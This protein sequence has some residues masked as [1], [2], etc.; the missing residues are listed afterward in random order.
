MSNT[1]LLDS[2][3]GKIRIKPGV[4][5]DDAQYVYKNGQCIALALALNKLTGWPIIAHL[6]R[7]GDLEG[8]SRL[9][10]RSIGIAQ[11]TNGWFYDFVHAMVLTRERRLVDIDGTANPEDY[12]E[13]AA[14]RYGSSALVKVS[15]PV[16][17]L[18]L[19]DARKHG[20]KWMA[21]N[22]LAAR[23][24]AITIRNQYE[25]VWSV[26]LNLGLALRPT[27]KAPVRRPAR[28]PT[29]R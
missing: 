13:D 17:R 7:P 23:A 29:G 18:A 11:A 4:I 10:G 24:F 20:A 16:L 26:Q 2:A 14:S 3:K 1:A 22:E 5:D 9:N 8:M 27:T 25:R 28:R 15:A 21:Q 6:A 12:L 19:A